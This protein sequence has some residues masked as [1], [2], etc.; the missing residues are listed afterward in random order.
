[1]TAVA[2]IGDT[3]DGEFSTFVRWIRTEYPSVIKNS[4][5]DVS[6]W[7]SARAAQ[8]KHQLTL[9]LQS[10]SDQFSPEDV[11][12]LVGGTLFSGLLCCFGSWCEGDGRTRQTWPCSTRVP[13][14]Y[15]KQVVHGEVRRISSGLPVLPPTAARDEVFFHRQTNHPPESTDRKGTALVISPD[16]IYRSTFAQAMAFYGWDV[17][18]ADL[19]S[20]KQEPVRPPDLVIH[21]LDPQGDV[22][23]ASIDLCAA[24]FPDAE[25]FGMANL[26]QELEY[27]AGIPFPVLPKLDPFLAVEQI[28]EWFRS[29]SEG[30]PSVVTLL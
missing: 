21:D 10:H 8:Q 26:P 19:A 30:W 11:G 12:L 15:A 27:V 5:V 22:V 3:A 4:F 20:A 7:E 24:R 16:A 1:M 6:E 17:T 9:V 13:V 14:R 29:A 23:T 25:I 2:L 18:D 28:L